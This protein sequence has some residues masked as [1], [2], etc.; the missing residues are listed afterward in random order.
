[1]PFDWDWLVQQSKNLASRAYA[2]EAAVAPE[3]ADEI[4][5]GAHQDIVQPID[6][7]L[8]ANGPGDCPVTFF[9]LGKLFPKPVRMYSLVDGSARPV[10]YRKS[11]FEYPPDN[12]AAR[13]P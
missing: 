9:H 5:Y 2:G 1:M 13:M 8:Y 12:P 10:I 4:D 6:T 3:I 11:L 7:G